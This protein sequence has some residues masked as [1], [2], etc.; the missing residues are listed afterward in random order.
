MLSSFIRSLKSKNSILEPESIAVNSQRCNLGYTQDMND[1]YFD[2]EEFK[3]I[4]FTQTKIKKG[5]YDNCTF[6][7]CNFSDVHASNIQFVECDFIDCNFS[8]A[9]VKDSAFRSATF[10]N[11]KMIGL[12]FHQLDPFLLQ[13]KFQNCQLN[14]SSFHGLKLNGTIFQGCQL[15]EVDFADSELTNVS[16]ENSDLKNA[17]FEQTNLEKADF[18]TATSF[19]I[20][21][22]NNRLKGAKFTKENCHGLLDKYKIIIE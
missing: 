4:D 7:E 14:F 19:R 16:F 15:E 11:C 12:K 17:I 2:E 13:M 3:K 18:R 5:E 22:D 10:S 9:I 1:N 20:D 21:P 8:N 6:T